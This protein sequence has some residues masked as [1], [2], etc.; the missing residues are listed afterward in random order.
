MQTKP[1]NT[2]CEAKILP[3]DAVTDF[4]E[5]TVD[6]LNSYERGCVPQPVPAKGWEKTAKG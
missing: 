6:I 2:S 1:I 5:A 3:E 4:Y